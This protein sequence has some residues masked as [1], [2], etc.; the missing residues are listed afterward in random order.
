MA[1][2]HQSFTVINAGADDTFKHQHLFGCRLPE[3]TWHINAGVI[4]MVFAQLACRGTFKPEV[5]FNIGDMGK[6]INRMNQ[7]QG[8]C[9]R[10]D[11][12]HQ[13]R[14]GPEE[15]DI[16]FHPLTDTRSQDL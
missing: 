5:K 1:G 6:L 7:F 16:L 12:F 14:H 15:T 2:S 8:A 10:R 3:N 9:L 4:G 13:T 11:K